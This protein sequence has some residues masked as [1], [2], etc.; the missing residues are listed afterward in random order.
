MAKE[1]ADLI[2]EVAETLNVTGVGETMSAEDRATIDARIEPKVAE[3]SSRGILYVPDLDDIPDE[4]FDALAT[5]V[6]EATAPAFG[7]PRN[8]ASRLEAEGRLREVQS[9]DGAGDTVSALYY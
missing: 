7:Q 6:A 9:G 5:L 2:Q 1:R 4:V 3:L 8:P